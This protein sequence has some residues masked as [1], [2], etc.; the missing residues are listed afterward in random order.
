LKHSLETRAI[1]NLYFAGQING[2]TG[3]E[4]AAAQ[5][6]LAG[7]NAAR[8]VAGLEPYLPG[9]DE[10]YIGVLVDDLVTKG[11]D[12][13]YR[14]FTSRAEYRILLRQDNA[15]ERLT[16]KGVEL[17]LATA[18]RLDRFREKEKKSDSLIGWLKKRSLDPEEIN[19]LLSEAGTNQIAQKTKAANIAL[20]PQVSLSAII[21]LFEDEIRKGVFKG[22]D[23]PDEVI[24]AAEIR[25]KYS[26]YIEREKLVADKIKRLEGLKIPD[27][28]EYDSL[29]SI[30]TEA[31]QKLGK[32]KPGTIGQASR[33]SGVSPSDISILLLY[34]GR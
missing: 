16:G 7:I 14:M 5:G 19:S 29:T 15:D 10:S 33:I 26:G 13:P 34:L 32:I 9:R 18:E 12:E 24:E 8:K 22:E 30:S 20:R 31:R 4:E 27:D 6:L 17:G 25:I 28:M 23:L 2:T 11:V 3:Y 21:K 1:E